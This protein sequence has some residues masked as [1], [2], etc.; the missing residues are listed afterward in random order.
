MQ[1]VF[2]YTR[3]DN[4]SS[5]QREQERVNQQ[6]ACLQAYI[7]HELPNQLVPI[8]AFARLLLED[9]SSALD[10]EGRT[11]LERLAAL[12]EKADRLAR[13]LAEINRLLRE[14]P[15]GLPLSLDELV[16][17]AI[18]E[19]NVPGIPAGITYDIQQSLPSVYAS[20]RLLHQV[21]VQLLRNA[22]QA[23]AAQPGRVQVSGRRESDGTWLEVRDTGRGLTADQAGLFEP[24]AA[25]RFPGAT[26]PGLGL[27][28]V[29]QAAALWGG[30]LRVDSQPGLG[31]TFA[32][33]I[34]DR[35]ERGLLLAES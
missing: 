3:K 18:A 9:S 12:T 27:F 11:M 20:R 24:F 34:P 6:M 31:S 15:W 23:M 32:L 26:G 33:F 10:E 19:V 35:Q 30:I 5:S 25:G 1:I 2:N 8:Q 13:R 21:L 28:L 14:P 16:R 4:C 29:A 17:E 7:G 22:G